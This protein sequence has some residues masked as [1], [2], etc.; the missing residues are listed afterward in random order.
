[1]IKSYAHSRDLTYAW[2]ENA[3][4]VGRGRY[5]EKYDHD[6]EKLSFIALTGDCL[7]PIVR[8]SDNAVYRIN[9]IKNSNQF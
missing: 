8:W 4:E 5:D 9:I 2:N 6:R 1:M 3:R 7:E